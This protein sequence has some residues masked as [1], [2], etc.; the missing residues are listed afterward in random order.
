MQFFSHT[1][2]ISSA[3]EPHV[4]S[5]YSI[6]VLDTADYRTFPSSQNVLLDGDAL[7]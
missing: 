2:H 1:S 7:E 4:A 6:T 3:Q 5:G